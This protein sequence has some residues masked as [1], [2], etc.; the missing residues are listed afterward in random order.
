[1]VTSGVDIKKQFLFQFTVPELQSSAGGV[2]Y[3]APDQTVSFEVKLEGYGISSVEWRHNDMETLPD[4]VETVTSSDFTTS[5]IAI[6]SFEPESHSG[7]YKFLVTNPAGV[8]VLTFWELQQ[9][10]NCRFYLG[11]PQ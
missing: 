2:E 4:G 9:A 5:E 7:V 11:N 8:S 3:A 1:M 6:A 10:G